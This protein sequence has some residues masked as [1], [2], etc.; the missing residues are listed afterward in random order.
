MDVSRAKLRP[1]KAAVVASLLVAFAAGTAG[2]HPHVFI[3]YAVTFL[4]VGDRVTGVRLAWTFDDLFSGFI[5]QEFDTDRNGVLSAAEVRRIEEKH[6]SEFHKV[7]YFTTVNVNGKPVAPSVAREFR[8]TAAKGIV[9]YE[10]TLPIG[11]A[12]TSTTAMEVLSDD[13]VYYIAY[14]PV[15]VTPQAQTF[16][17]HAVE[18][19]VARDK[20]GATPDAV[21]CGIRRR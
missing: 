19:Q 4:V 7:G 13:P 18:C 11:V 9:T 20:T 16:G 21:R 3:D 2:A 5:L 10:F 1:T 8:A 12:L 6:L 14:N 17:A 15:A